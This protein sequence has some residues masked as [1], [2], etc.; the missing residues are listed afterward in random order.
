[1]KNWYLTHKNCLRAKYNIN[2]H[3]VNTK[4]IWPNYVRTD[5]FTI[6]FVIDNLLQHPFLLQLNLI[7]YR[8]SINSVNPAQLTCPLDFFH[9]L[10]YFYM[11]ILSN[12]DE[13]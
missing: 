3:Y 13:F 11:L 1:M 6:N 5:K 10:I 12:P 4:K 8:D 9:L 2:L 7:A